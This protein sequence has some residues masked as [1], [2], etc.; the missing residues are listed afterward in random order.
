VDKFSANP[1]AFTPQSE[2]NRR[3]TNQV[4][5]GGVDFAGYEID[6]EP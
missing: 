3:K 2:G 1:I 5:R 4:R 6:V